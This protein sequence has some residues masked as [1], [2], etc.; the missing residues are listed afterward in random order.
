MRHASRLFLNR[1]DQVERFEA[2]AYLAD[3]LHTLR[4]GRR[5]VT[6]AVTLATDG[7]TGAGV[8]IAFDDGPEGGARDILG[9]A[10]IGEPELKAELQDQLLHGALYR[11]DP[12]RGLPAGWVP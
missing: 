6:Q 4:D 3:R 9:V 11:L 8:K 2:V 1:T 10:V 7:F 5:I 12:E